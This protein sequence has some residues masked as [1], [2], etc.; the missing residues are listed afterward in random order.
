[1][2]SCRSDCH[3]LSCIRCVVGHLLSELSL[4]MSS[5]RSHYNLL[6]I[7]NVTVSTE[8]HGNSSGAL[9]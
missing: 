7:P 6:L 8:G 5:K 4:E 2:W 3:D 9:I 1:M